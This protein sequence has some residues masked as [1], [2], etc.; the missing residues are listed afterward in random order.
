MATVCLAGC[1]EEGHAPCEGDLED[2]LRAEGLLPEAEPHRPPPLVLAPASAQDGEA[3]LVDPAPLARGE[4]PVLRFRRDPDTCGI[5]REVVPWGPPPGAAPE[6]TGLRH[7]FAPPEP[8]TS[9]VRALL[10]TGADPGAPKDAAA[11]T[12][13]LEALG[14]FGFHLQAPDRLTVETTLASLCGDV[15]PAHTV[16]LVTAGRATPA[17]DG[18][19][20]LGPEAVSFDHLLDL[21]ASECAGAGLRVWVNDAAWSAGL[22][23]RASATAPLILWRASDAAHPDA[24]R[25]TPEGGGLLSA[26][27]APHVEARA[28]ERCLRGANPSP[29]EVADVFD[30]PGEVRARM[31]ALRVEALGEDDAAAEAVTSD[32]PEDVRRVLGEPPSVGGCDDDVPCLLRTSGCALPACTTLAC[33]GGRCVPVADLGEPCDDGSPC[34]E[35][36]RCDA[37]ATCA[38]EPVDCSDGEPCTTD[39]CD[40]DLG[41]VHE[42]LPDGEACDDGD[43]CTLDDRCV[44]GACE[45]ETRP[46]DDGDPCT[47]DLCDPATGC[48]HEVQDG[49][50]DD[51]DPCTHEDFCDGGFC[52]GEPVHC[53]DGDPCTRDLCTPEDGCVFPPAPE[54]LACDDGDP[55]TSLDRCEE[56]T[57]TGV[58]TLCD[59]GLDCTLDQ[60]EAGGCVHLPE[61][62]TCATADGCIPVGTHPPD[63]PCMVCQATNSL[64]PDPALEGAPCDDDGLAC[65][66]D[67]CEGGACV[68]PPLPGFCTGPDG[69]CVSV[70]QPLTPCL[71]CVATGVASPAAPGSACDDGDPCTDGDACDAVGLCRGTPRGCCPPGDDVACGTLLEGDTSLPGTP[72][73]VDV[74]GCLTGLTFG[75]AERAHRFVAP[76]DGQFTFHLQETSAHI[77]FVL[78]GD[79]APPE[80]AC[81]TASCDTY[82]ATTITQPLAVGQE[83]LLVVDSNAGA[84]GPY[85][86]DVEC[87][88]EEEAP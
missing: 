88:C 41:C 48:F 77:L 37:T 3:L 71:T 53:D 4:H 12:P 34:T 76:C 22:E 70:G 19:L 49:P 7:S 60:C 13:A 54:G 61:P 83:A 17:G 47:A 23:E 30:A 56:G 64:V 9:R 66:A 39:A 29:A 78:R 16:V 2:V 15:A 25:T 14:V 11:W 45:G 86:L 51:G 74:W 79:D 18:A 50:C 65:T 68:H 1:A 59:D 84:G 85:T 42:D 46:C 72:A 8:K 43:V 87:A 36:D 6:E 82:T 67:R 27:L 40:D 28:L 26:A 44:A 73:V 32:V 33:N 10:V 24:P 20:L 5:T 80:D 35:G 55:C 21:L 75:G 57:C 52:L 38:G 62:G 63:A 58:P 31:S 81:A 69:D